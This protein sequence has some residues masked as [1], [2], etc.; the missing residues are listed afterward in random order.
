[1]NEIV[2]N[3]KERK[4]NQINA[5][6]GHWSASMAHVSSIYLGSVHFSNIAISSICERQMKIDW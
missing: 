3:Q 2:L 6:H 5:I 4:E 1:M